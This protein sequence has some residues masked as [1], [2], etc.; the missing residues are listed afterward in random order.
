MLFVLMWI[1]WVVVELGRSKEN[2]GS[3]AGFLLDYELAYKIVKHDVFLIS[4]V[5]LLRVL[6]ILRFHIVL[7]VHNLDKTL[8]FGN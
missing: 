1:I 4:M 8:I 7:K 6:E 2:R 3:A 5:V